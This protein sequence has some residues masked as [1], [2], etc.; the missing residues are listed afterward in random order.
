MN[1]NQVIK[2]GA[3]F[4]LQSPCDVGVQYFQQDGTEMSQDEVENQFGVLG[5]HVP[6]VDPPV[7][8]L[9]RMDR[10]S[11][12]QKVLTVRVIDGDGN[13]MQGVMVGLAP[14]GISA[15]TRKAPTGPGGVVLFTLDK[16]AYYAV[17]D[18]APRFVCGIATVASW[19]VPV[20]VVRGRTRRDWLNPTFQFTDEPVVP[21]LSMWEILF[22][23]LDTIIG[24]LEDK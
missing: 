6:K 9:A 22:G 3:D 20:G 23:K 11:G 18:Q 4:F 1:F 19:V 7:F 15:E 10:C 12:D 2:D 16:S 24:L 5:I 21:E 8:K 17:P 14:V 13:P